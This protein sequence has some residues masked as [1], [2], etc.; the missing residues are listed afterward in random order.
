MEKTGLRG[1]F[2][3]DLSQITWYRLVHIKW[4]NGINPIPYGLKI[5][6]KTNGIPMKKTKLVDYKKKNKIRKY[7]YSKSKRRN[8]QK[9][10]QIDF[11]SYKIYSSETKKLL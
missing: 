3:Y 5:K 9:K 7:I 10:L 4:R 1:D 6:I 2:Q 11:Y 8:F